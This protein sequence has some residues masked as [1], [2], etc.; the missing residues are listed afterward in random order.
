MA[1]NRCWK[2][3]TM[4]TEALNTTINIRVEMNEDGKPDYSGI[5]LTGYSGGSEAAAQ[6]A[7]EVARRAVTL[8][9][10]QGYDLDPAKYAQW[11]VLNMTF[12]PSG[13]RMR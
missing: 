9:G 1:I 13:M 11:N 4:S 12:D 6:V 10:K 7:F 2:V 5:T 8:C 3:G